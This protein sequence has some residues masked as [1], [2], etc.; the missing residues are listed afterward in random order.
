MQSM[1][2]SRYMQRCCELALLGR[3]KVG[4]G[5]LVGAVLVRDGNIIAEGYYIEY[6]NSHAERMLLEKFDQEIR[7]TDILY[8]S[9]EPCCHQGKTP[10]CTDIIIERGVKHIVY[11]MQDPDQRV[12]GQGT[13]T[14]RKAGIEVIGPVDRALCERLSRGFVT[15]RTKNRP[16]ITLKKAMTKDGRT[17]NASGPR[18]MITNAEQDA[19][20]H[21][22]LRSEVDGIVVG[23]HTIETDNPQ[24]NTRLT[25]KKYSQ[26]GLEPYRIIF[27]VHARIPLDAY[28]VTDDQKHRTIVVVSS[29][30]Q[31]S[32]SAK[33]LRDRG[34]RVVVVPVDAQGMF[35][36]SELFKTLITPA[37]DYTGLTSLLIEG[38]ARTWE[39]FQ[40][41]GCI[42]EEVTLMGK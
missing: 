35:V 1:D 9:L 8:T 29:E 14:L 40:K 16:W 36:S 21:T 20:A 34:V 15:V 28:V 22:Y 39:Y 32:E 17:A 24:L 19:W 37:G 38:G 42:D 18:L 6:G 12:A 11:G 2:H 25:Q 3:G 31:D 7:S 33:A 23:V 13:A 41:A 30:A 4:N 5:A 10:P 27:D 26:E